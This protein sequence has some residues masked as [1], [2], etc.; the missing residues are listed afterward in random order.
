MKLKQILATSG[1]AYKRWGTGRKEDLF[2]GFLIRGGRHLPLIRSI[3]D[4]QISKR[5]IVD[6]I[7]V[8]DPWIPFFLKLEPGV[9]IGYISLSDPEV[10]KLT[11]NRKLKVPAIMSLLHLGP[12]KARKGMPCAPHDH[13]STIVIT[14]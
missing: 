8:D 2:L 12:V 6:G 14:V 1:L 3:N 7:G 5:V 4:D 9:N 11:P 13:L 10:Q